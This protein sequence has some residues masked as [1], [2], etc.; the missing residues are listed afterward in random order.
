MRRDFTI[1]SIITILFLIIFTASSPIQAEE[2][3]L[4]IDLADITI[5]E[6]RGVEPSPFH[7][8]R[9]LT[10]EEYFISIMTLNSL[11]GAQ[12][13]T[14]LRMSCPPDD[15]Y[16]AAILWSKHFMPT[17]TRGVLPS[18]FIV[19][20]DYTMFHFPLAHDPDGTPLM[21]GTWQTISLLQTPDMF[22][23]ATC[24]AELPGSEFG[25]GKP[26]LY[27][28]TD[29]GHILILVET[30]EAGI[31]VEGGFWHSYGRIDDL[32]PIPQYGYI[33]LGALAGNAIYGL[34][35]RTTRDGDSRYMFNFRLLDPRTPPMTDFD[36]IGPN[37]APLSDPADEV[38][39]VIANGTGELGIASLYAEELGDV[40]LTITPDTK[41]ENIGKIA[42][43]S[44][45][46]I[47]TNRSTVLYDPH[48]N[49]DDGS[50]EC[51]S[52][53]IG[54][55]PD[56]CHYICADVDND[57]NVNI[58]DIVYLINYKYKEGPAPYILR[59]GDVDGID[60]IN[61][62]DIIYLINSIYKE[63]PDPDCP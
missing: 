47:P 32:E 58:L 57:G 21:G 2:E 11:N 53:L 5:G 1:R 7:L 45:L 29:E 23:D 54:T 12:L 18:P 17:I 31:I 38:K 60:P 49:G 50:S 34:D 4:F 63:G 9:D 59:L 20:R 27:I 16:P 24:A 55:P 13:G 10:S 56:P 26:R 40:T 62:L 39:I 48:F 51:E 43:G 52:E 44:L 28:G 8:S 25:D 15:G 36:V 30:A 14:T 19:C 37:D 6:A 42:S 61:I 41:G 35:H 3:Y 22:G 46:M 33:A